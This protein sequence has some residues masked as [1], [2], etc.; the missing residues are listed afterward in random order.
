LQVCRFAGLSRFTWRGQVC[1]CLRLLAQ[2][3]RRSS[4]VY[5]SSRV[6][7]ALFLVHDT[8]ISVVG[9]VVRS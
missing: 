7:G 2:V 4:A 1:G 8:S 3:Q 6:Q 5:E 9:A